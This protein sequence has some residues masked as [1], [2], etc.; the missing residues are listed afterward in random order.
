MLPVVHFGAYRSVVAGGR[1]D[2]ERFGAAARQLQCPHQ[3]AANAL[4]VT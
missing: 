3:R 1:R 2:V 4:I